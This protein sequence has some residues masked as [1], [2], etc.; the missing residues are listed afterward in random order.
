MV[1]KKAEKHFMT[2]EN[3]MKSINKILLEHGHASFMQSN[4]NRT[5]AIA[6]KWPAEPTVFPSGPLQKRFAAH[7]S[8]LSTHHPAGC[9]Q[10]S[11]A[12]KAQFPHL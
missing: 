8:K 2:H 11:S 12:A 6:T 1:R 5:V 10:V 7:S 9:E 4:G 3:D